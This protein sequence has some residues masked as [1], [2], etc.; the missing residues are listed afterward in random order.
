M[1]IFLFK[2]YF[3]FLYEKFILREVFNPEYP[4]FKLLDSVINSL[5]VKNYTYSKY[6]NEIRLFSQKEIFLS[7]NEYR[8]FFYQLVRRN[9][10][11]TIVVNDALKKRNQIKASSILTIIQITFLLSLG[12]CFNLILTSV[13]FEKREGNQLLFTGFSIC[14]CIFLASHFLK[15]IVNLDLSKYFS[16]EIITNY[17]KK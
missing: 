2:N 8:Q 11:L 15:V 13:S 10:E 9:P 4:S 17:E 5:A 7:F 6:L 12:Y 14:F 3:S 1:V 16:S